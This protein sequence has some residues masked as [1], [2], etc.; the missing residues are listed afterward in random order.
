M[1]SPISAAAPRRAGAGIIDGK[2]EKKPNTFTDFIACGEALIEAGYTS[3]GRIVAHGG[4]AGGM[5]MG[6]VANLAPD[7]FAG[8]IAEVPFVDVLNTMLDSELPLTPPEWPE[9]GNPGADE[10]AFRTHPV[11]L[12]LRQREAAE[13]IRPS[14]RSPASPIR[15]SP[16]GSRPNGSRGSGPP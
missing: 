14:W 11:L 6:A 10:A 2:R 12:A 9:W 5:L 15:A 1:R 3:R 4:S 13:P 8:I 7:L 16:I